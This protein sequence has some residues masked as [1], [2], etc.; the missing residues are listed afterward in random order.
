MNQQGGAHAEPTGGAGLGTRGVAAE[1]AAIPRLVVGCYR[2]DFIGVNRAGIDFPEI[3][4][5]R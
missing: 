5:A 3:G 2:I 4:A 1:P